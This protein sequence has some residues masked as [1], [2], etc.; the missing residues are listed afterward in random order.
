MS[1]SDQAVCVLVVE[2]EMSYAGR[3][4]R[5]PCDIFLEERKGMVLQL[6]SKPWQPAKVCRWKGRTCGQIRDLIKTSTSQD[7]EF[8]VALPSYR[9]A[10]ELQ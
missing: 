10:R 1:H 4:K 2:A 6:I 8:T 5:H 3:D 9:Y 7:M